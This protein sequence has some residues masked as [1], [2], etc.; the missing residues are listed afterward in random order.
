MRMCVACSVTISPWCGG[1]G[2][3]L[4][5]GLFAQHVGDGWVKLSAG[6]F[7]VVLTVLGGVLAVFFGRGLDRVGL[8]FGHVFPLRFGRWLDV[9][10]GLVVRFGCCFLWA[11]P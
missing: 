1:A 6:S 7:G 4:V 11:V 8:S 9:L 10:F 2:L 5:L 3:A